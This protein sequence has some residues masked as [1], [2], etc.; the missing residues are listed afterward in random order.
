MREGQ[1]E[2]RGQ[3]WGLHGAQEIPLLGLQ[4]VLKGCSPPTRQL[5]SSPAA[6]CSRW[7]LRACCCALAAAHPLHTA[8][9][10]LQRCATQAHQ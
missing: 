6:P 9:P 10:A 4:P 5:P 3:S 2:R 1:G 7:L 8:S